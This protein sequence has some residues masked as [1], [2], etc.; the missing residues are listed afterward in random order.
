MLKDLIWRHPDVFIDMPGETSVI[1]YRV[2]LTDD[3]PIGCKPYPLPYAITKELRN[4][5]D[6]MPEMGVVR[7][8]N[9]VEVDQDHRSR[10]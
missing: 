6:R 2:K 4:E 7:P 3:T 9:R 8:S 1:Q 5:V 10:P